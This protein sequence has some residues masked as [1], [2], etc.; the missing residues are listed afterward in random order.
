MDGEYISMGCR[1]NR[2]GTIG[3]Q[4][5]LV[6][7]L[8][9]SANFRLKDM[10]SPPYIAIFTDEKPIIITVADKYGVEPYTSANE[11]IDWKGPQGE[12]FKSKGNAPSLESQ[13]LDTF[14][15]IK[16][17]TE[18]GLD[19]EYTDDL[20]LT[21][22]GKIEKTFKKGDKTFYKIEGVDRPFN[23]DE[24]ATYDKLISRLFSKDQEGELRELSEI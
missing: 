23:S 15:Q 22:Y 4:R 20:A 12:Y 24:I 10:S 5:P 1:S 11:S 13:A 21:R 19:V 16:D 3:N 7:V 17:M 9:T 8:F 14:K 18:K 2:V 6:E